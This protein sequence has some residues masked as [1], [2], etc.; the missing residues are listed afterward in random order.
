MQVLFKNGEYE[1]MFDRVT[2]I[3]Q[4]TLNTWF[5]IEPNDFVFSDVYGE[6]YASELP[7]E[8]CHLVKSGSIRGWRVKPN[9]NIE[10]TAHTS[11]IDC[12]R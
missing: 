6:Y 5:E 1:F 8:L 9:G 2:G 3:N 4:M 12:I 11:L 10:I 7:N